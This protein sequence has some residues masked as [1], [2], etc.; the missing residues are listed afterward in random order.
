M[1]IGIILAC[2]PT[3]RP[4]FH[5]DFLDYLRS[6]L[7]RYH[8]KFHQIEAGH[9]GPADDQQ[10]LHQVYSVENALHMN[11]SPSGPENLISSQAYGNVTRPEGARFPEPVFYRD[12][13]SKTTEF[14]LSILN[15]Q[16]DEHPR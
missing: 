2:V 1:S 5:S 4:L 8:S 11:A 3:I 15:Q 14:E 9:V 12:G 16:R 13:I 7:G 6:H 10:R